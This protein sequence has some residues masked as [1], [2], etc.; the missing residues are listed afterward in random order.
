MTGSIL[1]VEDEPHL[2]ET[3]AD[4]LTSQGYELMRAATCSEAREKAQ[5]R[6]PEFAVVDVGL[7][8]GSGFEL[9]RELIS[10]DPSL[11]VLFLTAFSTPED[12]LRGLELGAVD[13]IGKPFHLRELILRL[14]NL[15]VPTPARSAWVTLGQA[16]V[17]FSEY[18]IRNTSSERALSTKECTLL[19]LL[20]DRAPNAVSREDMIRLAW[21]SEGEDEAPTTRTI[22]NF[23][24]RLRRWIERNPA[25][26][27]ILISV[28]GV[29]YALKIPTPG[30]RS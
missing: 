11:R 5:T 21:S 1:L 22:D 14:R 8:D 29:G 7:P 23:V 19:K 17:N 16:Q 9:A 15:S 13:Y 3:L 10:H 25:R 4:A 20:I 28:W 26:P 24:G 2:R 12:R 18:R 30:A 27:E 6:K